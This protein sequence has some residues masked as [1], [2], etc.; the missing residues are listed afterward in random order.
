MPQPQHVLVHVVVN[1]DPSGVVSP[2]SRGQQHHLQRQC[3]LPLHAV[4]FGVERSDL[5]HRE[6]QRR[7]RVRRPGTQSHRSGL[8]LKIKPPK[9]G[10]KFIK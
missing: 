10:L 6:L 3:R 8:L 5:H 9:Q 2:Q 1:E 4:R 7:L